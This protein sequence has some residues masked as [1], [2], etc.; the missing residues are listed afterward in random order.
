M[1]EVPPLK[2]SSH[3]ILVE[4]LKYFLGVNEPEH[5][6]LSMLE[7]ATW[8]LTPSARLL[9]LLG[10]FVTLGFELEVAAEF[11]NSEPWHFV[12]TL[13][14]DFGDTHSC[15]LSPKEGSVDPLPLPTLQAS[16]A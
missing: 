2:N 1:E 11:V 5:V 7:Q 6:L 10:A 3:L 9:G 8:A 12:R 15:Q 16:S 13:F 14:V 4:F